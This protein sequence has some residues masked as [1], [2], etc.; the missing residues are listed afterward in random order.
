MIKKIS[1]L[2]LVLV[3]VIVFLPS[4][5]TYAKTKINTRDIPKYANPEKIKKI[6]T[7]LLK[8]QFKNYNEGNL[9]GSMKYMS[10]KYTNDR[11]FRASDYELSLQEDFSLTENNLKLTAIE[12]INVSKSYPIE[13]EVRYSFVKTVT[14][15]STGNI[16]RVRDT[17]AVTKFHIKVNPDMLTR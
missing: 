17:N 5:N 13:V 15:T 16:I 12:S 6:A 8:H 3:M 7:L 11:G 2:F 4:Q 1:L 14:D 9:N 10:E